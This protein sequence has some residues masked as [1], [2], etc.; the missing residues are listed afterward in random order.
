M[1]N[2]KTSNLKQTPQSKC[3]VKGY[4]RALQPPTQSVRQLNQ[5]AAHEM[6]AIY[7]G[8]S[9]RTFSLPQTLDCLLCPKLFLSLFYGFINSSMQF[10]AKFTQKLSKAL[11]VR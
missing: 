11:T 1:N 7:T 5:L 8:K 10:Y 6:A 3:H 4:Q 2:N 9:V